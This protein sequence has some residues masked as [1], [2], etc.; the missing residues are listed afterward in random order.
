MSFPLNS[1]ENDHQITHVRSQDT[2][3]QRLEKLDM[4]KETSPASTRS[5]QTILDYQDAPSPQEL[6]DVI[7]MDCKSANTSTEQITNL[8]EQTEKDDSPL[9]LEKQMGKNLLPSIQNCH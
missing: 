4:S 2:S 7:F 6:E 3:S 9:D 8:T 1:P 5:D